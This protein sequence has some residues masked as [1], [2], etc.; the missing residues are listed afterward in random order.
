MKIGLYSVSFSGLWYHG[1]VLS[2]EEL[3]DIA[4]ELNFDGLELD[5]K[6]P[7]GF[8]LDWSQ[9]RREDFKAY[10]EQKGIEIIGVAGNNN[11]V[12]PFEEDFEN[13]LLMLSEQ[14]RLCHDL[15]GKIV[16]V[17]LAWPKIVRV[18]GLGTYSIPGKYAIK[19]TQS[20]IDVSNRQRW[21]IAKKLLTEAVKIAEKYDVVMALQNHHPYFMHTLDTYH[22][23]LRMVQ[24]V[25][26]E[27]LKCSLDCPLLASQD[28]D[29][30]RKAV[31]EV[32]SL[33]VINHYGGEFSRDENGKAIQVKVTGYDYGPFDYPA[34]VAALKE[35]GYN[36][37]FS[38]EFCHTYLNDQYEDNGL[39]GVIKQVTLARAY[40]TD[41]INGS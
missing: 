32:G 2:V 8:P 24:Q 26:S 6:R 5:G 34:Y 14:L 38:F 19:G 1:K 18:D 36:G 11:L 13:E 30:I 22:D 23:M 37:Y 41:L 10:A 4:A 9:R 27:Y 40:M 3:V 35:I 16:R 21:H 20:G 12:S 28:A 29:Y 15:G 31:Y 39:E 25:D 7:H 17:F 33:Q